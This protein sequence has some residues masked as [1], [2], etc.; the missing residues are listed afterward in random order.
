LLLR[1]MRGE[2]LQKHDLQIKL[3]PELIVRGTAEKPRN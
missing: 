1:L 3:R 2:K